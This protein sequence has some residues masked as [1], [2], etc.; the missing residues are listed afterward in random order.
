MT[1]SRQDQVYFRPRS[2]EEWQTPFRKDKRGRS[3]GKRF[4]AMSTDLDSDPEFNSL[5]PYQRCLWLGILR[6]YGKTARPLP[7]DCAHT[8]RLLSL[9]CRNIG[10]GLDALLSL[11]FIEI[12]EREGN[13]S[14]QQKGKGK[15]ERERKDS[16]ATLGT[17]PAGDPPGKEFDPAKQ[18]FDFGVQLLAS[19]GIKNQKARALI[20]KWRKVRKDPDL[21][22]IL[23]RAGE[24]RRFEIVPFI[25]GSLRDQVE[26]PRTWI[27]RERQKSNERMD[28]IRELS[29]VDDGEPSPNTSDCE[30]LHSLS[31]GAS[32]SDQREPSQTGGQRLHQNGGQRI[33]RPNGGGSGAG[34][35]GVFGDLGGGSMADPGA[36][37]PGADGQHAKASNGEDRSQTQTG[38][39]K[40]RCGPP[41]LGSRSAGD[42]RGHSELAL[43]LG[44]EE[45]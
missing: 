34:D 37:H 15:G 28:Y 41:A 25:E 42:P 2:W 6:L 44:D 33:P 10:K 8:G 31:G 5:T 30:A 24:T 17:S 9:D 27:E 45:S 12:V 32:G 36:I 11:N 23:L 18:L 14:V 7:W 35:T 19:Y 1:K 21:M 20:G 29:G 22:A 3:C 39:R 26:R 38:P 40:A 43:G 16:L 4:V 13:A